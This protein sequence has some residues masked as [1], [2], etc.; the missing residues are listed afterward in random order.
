MNM[1]KIC[2]LARMKDSSKPFFNK[3]PYKEA[4]IEA[5]SED[6]AKQKLADEF[7]MLDIVVKGIAAVHDK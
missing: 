4:F 1:Y 7:K 6:E 3:D 5:A 2:Y